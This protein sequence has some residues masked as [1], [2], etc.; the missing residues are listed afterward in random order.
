MADCRSGLDGLELRLG[1]P[2][3]VVGSSTVEFA[4]CVIGRGEIED[5]LALLD[6][7]VTDKTSALLALLVH[8]STRGRSRR[9]ISSLAWRLCALE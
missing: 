4:G 1:A 2:V 6:A 8:S 7:E 3:V 9:R 5:E